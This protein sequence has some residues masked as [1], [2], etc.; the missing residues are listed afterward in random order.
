MDA[1]DQ[2]IMHQMILVMAQAMRD[3]GMNVD[4]QSTDWGTVV[5]R[6]A[7]NDRPGAG[8]R[9][10]HM[11]ASW[12]P[13]RVVGSPLT[14]TQLRTTCNLTTFFPSPCD[15]ELEAR[16]DRYFA[17]TTLEA[18][19]QAMDALQERFYEIVPYLTGGQFLAP[20]A[21]RNAVT[22]V[23]NASEFVFWGVDKK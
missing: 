3:A 15:A 8:S 11:Y 21:W 1:A 9:G 19:K 5:T 23:V 14:A 17:A 20:K 13:G 4:L 6:S 18:R 22:G 10:W 7:R 12:A 16:R 2:P